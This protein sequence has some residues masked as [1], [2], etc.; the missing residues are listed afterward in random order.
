MRVLHTESSLNW[1]GQE[2]RTLLEHRYLNGNGHQSWI[3]CHV[4]SQLY[5]QSKKMNDYSVIA[6]DLSKR[7][8]IKSAIKILRFCRDHKI[9]VINS[10]SS[11]DTFLCLLAYVSGIPLIRSR[12]IT[13]LVKGSFSYKYLCSHVIAAAERISDIL[14]DVGVKKEKVDV[15][16]EGVDL[17]EY[18]SS[19]DSQY[20]RE[21]F[22]IKETD[23]VIV[24]IGM[25][26][27]DKGQRFLLDAA[28]EI[29]K[30][31]QRIKFFLI[32]EGTGNKELENELKG[33]VKDYNLQ[34]NFI[35]VGYREDVAAFISLSDLV[36]VASTGTEAQS[37]V[38]PQ[39][40]ATKRTVVTTNTGGLTE[41]VDNNINGLVVPPEDAYALEVAIKEILNDEALKSRLEDNAYKSA[42]ENLSFEKMMN[43]ILSIY[44][45]FATD[46]SRFV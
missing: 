1:G 8:N 42:V 41:L 28:K 4:D 44:T 13:N 40:F 6:I 23:S 35:M 9:N 38:V 19:V 3:M 15:V 26:R 45:R 36:V 5:K 22:G 27:K 17:T 43:K 11:K 2:F 31:D 33:L 7:W 14:V 29:V 12:Q 34:S 46:Q 10:H 30:N 39:A 37:R 24:N 21:E 32:G 16:G 20:L 18:T 25:I